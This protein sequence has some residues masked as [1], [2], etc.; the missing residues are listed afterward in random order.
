MTSLDFLKLTKKRQEYFE[1][2][3]I[4]TLEDMLH[5]FPYKYDIIEETYPT[6]SSDKV[7]IEAR[8][9]SVP[10]IFFRGRMSRMSFSVEDAFLHEYT[11]TIF[12]RH[13]LKQYLTLGKTITIIGKMEKNKITASDVK[14]QPLNE[15]KGIHPVYSIKDGMQ[16]KTFVK[17]MNQCLE[18]M[19]N[20]LFSYVPNDYRIKHKLL[21]KNDAIYKIHKPSSKDDIKESLR[22]LK[23]EEFLK[24]QLTMQC[25]KQQREEDIGI[26]KDFDVEKIKQL[27]ATLPY[28][29]TKDQKDVLKDIVVDLRK[30]QMMYRF[31]QGDVGSGKTVV[32]ALGLYA[33]YLAGY[34]GALMAPTEILAQQHFVSLSRFFKDTD[35][36]IGLLTGSLSIK[37]KESLQLQIQKGD[38]DIIIGT[39]ALF[40]KKVSYAN[41]GFIITDEQHRFGVNQRKALRDKGQKVDFL[42]MSAT[43]IPRTLALSLY[44]DMDVS[45]IKSMPIGRKKVKTEYIQSDSM[46]PILGHLEDYLS[47]G[48]QCYVV[49]PLVEESDAL[50]A[51]SAL[52]ISEAMR[53]YFKERFKV[54]LVHGQMKQDEKDDIMEKF[55]NNEIQILVSTTVIEVGVDVK[56]ANMIVIYN[57]ERFG[58][59]QLHQLRGR[60]GRSDQ[61]AF[62]YLLSQS[63][64]EEAIARLKYLEDCHDGFE[65]SMYDLKMRGPGEVLGQ[66][67]SGLPTFLVAD[68]MKD[69]PILTIAKDD[70]STIINEYEKNRHYED[71]MIHIEKELQDNNEYVD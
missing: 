10:K 2:M 19:K 53:S 34:Q 27:I 51:K 4:Y 44:G 31:L 20:D 61:Q 33:N 29:L 62:C 55:Q 15:L 12:N 23:Y 11:V 18:Q 3:E 48:G 39:H 32:S 47:K 45:T 71:I 42:V 41:L 25:M 40:Q 59:S 35:V 70:A 46:K 43:P 26:A 14:L 58:M 66:R 60:V 30:P 16:Q 57:A 69:F 9:L 64:N 28:E 36:K 67:Q 13:F 38:I 6:P 8:I 52:Q 21:E 65:I 22:F 37:E 49:C 1:M 63:Q 5:Y 54:G 24:F 68:I 56:N 50:S 17:L 7:I